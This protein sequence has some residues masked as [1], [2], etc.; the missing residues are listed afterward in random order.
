MEKNVQYL[1][2]YKEGKLV[3]SVFEAQD[4]FKSY[5]DYLILNSEYLSCTWQFLSYGNIRD[6]KYRK[7][8]KSTCFK[9]W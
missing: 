9:D 6:T 4:P 1:R 8:E 2:I 7:Q 5:T 3:F